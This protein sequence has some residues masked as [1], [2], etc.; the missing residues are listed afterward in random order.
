[1]RQRGYTAG[2]WDDV[3]AGKVSLAD[4]IDRAREKAREAV[5]GL[6]EDALASLAEGL[7]PAAAQALGKQPSE[8]TQAELYSFIASLPTQ[9]IAQSVREVGLQSGK[10]IASSVGTAVALGLGGIA[11]VLYLTRRK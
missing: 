2:F 11:L 7:R 3:L 9:Q 6:S 8:V 4:A 10:A 1:M 5:G